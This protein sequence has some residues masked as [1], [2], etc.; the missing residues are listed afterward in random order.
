VAK[1]WSSPSVP[2]KWISGLPLTGLLKTNTPE[3]GLA[4]NGKVAP[5]GAAMTLAGSTCSTAASTLCVG[6]P[7]A[8]LPAKT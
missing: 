8:R 5:A 3:R 7:K 6:T 2:T 1:P 4:D